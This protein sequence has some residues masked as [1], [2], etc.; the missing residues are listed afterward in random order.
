[1]KSFELIYE[2]RVREVYNVMAES[3]DEARAKW[4]NSEPVVSEVVDGEITEVKEGN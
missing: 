2:G 4:M 3:E 1:M